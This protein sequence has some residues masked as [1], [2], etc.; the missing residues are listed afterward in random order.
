MAIVFVLL[1]R[2]VWHLQEEYAKKNIDLPKEPDYKSIDD[3]VVSVNEK[4]IRIT[5]ER[6]A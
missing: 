4:I 5:A 1:E 2:S 6:N 3:F